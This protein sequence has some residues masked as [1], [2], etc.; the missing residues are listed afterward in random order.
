MTLTA[1]EALNRQ[2]LASGE[3]QLQHMARNGNAQVRDLG[4]V[5][6]A[7]RS[8]FD[9]LDRNGDGLLDKAEFLKSAEK[10]LRQRLEVMR[11]ASRNKTRFQFE[12][13]DGLTKETYRVKGKKKGD[14][15][16]IFVE[17]QARKR[18]NCGDATE[19]PAPEPLS[20]IHI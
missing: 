15:D 11:D 4:S 8:G 1:L 7:L 12:M 2:G 14:A 20:L 13:Y 18:Y 5:G 19:D 9:A 17:K 16:R 10:A 3:K 6:P